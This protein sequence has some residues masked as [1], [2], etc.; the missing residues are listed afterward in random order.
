MTIQILTQPKVQ[1]LENI[2]EVGALLTGDVILMKKNGNRRP[3]K[4]L[5]EEIDSK[6]FT[7]VIRDCDYRIKRIIVDGEHSELSKDKFLIANQIV[8]FTYLKNEGK[9]D[10]YDE[11]L[12]GAGIEK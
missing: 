7:L 3:T 2:E 11:K 12:T 1:E 10:F 9:Y 8:E 6:K 5:Y 4:A